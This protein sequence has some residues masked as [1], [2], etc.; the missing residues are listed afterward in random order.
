MTS[1]KAS[2]T[3]AQVLIYNQL[4][5][6]EVMLSPFVVCKSLTRSPSRQD[7]RFRDPGPSQKI[8]GGWSSWGSLSY[9]LWWL[10]L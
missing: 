5:R 3:L 8:L 9:G 1:T 6:F 10:R 7:L 2:T 4:F